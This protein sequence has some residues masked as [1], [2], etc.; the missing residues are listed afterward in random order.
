MLGGT[1]LLVDDE[2]EITQLLEIYLKNEGFTLLTAND[3]LE[4]LELLKTHHVDLIINRSCAGIASLT[5]CPRRTTTKS[6]SMSSSIYKGLI[7]KPI[8]TYRRMLVYRWQS[9]TRS[10]SSMWLR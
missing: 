4:A 1:I 2:K 5:A 7:Y 10:L 6:L 9:S 8:G 3:G